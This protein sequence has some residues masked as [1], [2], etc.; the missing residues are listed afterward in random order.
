[1]ISMMAY[2]AIG[3]ALGATIRLAFDRS[4]GWLRQLRVTPVPPSA[5]LAVDVLVGALLVLPSLVVVALVGRFVTGVQ[6]GLGS[7]LALVGVL[8]AGS[9][10]FVALGVAVGLVLDSQAAEPRRHGQV[11]SSRD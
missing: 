8:W 9:V 1:M 2:G 6:L 7:W 10:V 11:R 4:S 5:V 3:A